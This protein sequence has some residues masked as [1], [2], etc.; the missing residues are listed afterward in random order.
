MPQLA[1]AF[2]KKGGGVYRYRPPTMALGEK[3]GRVGVID[4]LVGMGLW[5]DDKKLE[6]CELWM[7]RAALHCGKS[8]G[9]RILSTLSH[10]LFRQCV[11]T[12]RNGQRP[13]GNH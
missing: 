4:I 7:L 3:Q 6:Q 12:P 11:D 13:H 5:T 9:T 1:Q 2:D 10:A 8:F